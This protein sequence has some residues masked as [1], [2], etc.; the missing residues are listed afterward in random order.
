MTIA[1][2]VI[3]YNYATATQSGGSLTVG[4]G[5][6]PDRAELYNAAASVWN[7]AD[8]SGAT[9]GAD[10]ASFIANA[11][12][13]EKTGGTGT[14]TIAT[15]VTNTG[16]I[17]AAS[18]V[19]DFQGAVAGTGADSISDASTLEFDSSAAAGQTV[20]FAGSGGT[21]IIGSLQTF[22][23]TLS[24]Y[25]IGG[26]GGTNDAIRLLGSWSE[27]G[28]SE[29][30]GD[31]LGT[32]TLFNGTVHETLKFAGSYTSA[33]FHVSRWTAVRT[34]RRLKAVAS[35][36]EIRPRRTDVAVCE[37]SSPCRFA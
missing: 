28:F 31:T 21:L 29:N 16:R 23:A 33:S 27:T 20:G 36:E 1:G 7:I 32:L 34:V 13:F 3:V 8:N 17:L 11:G 35:G 25:D 14:S 37:R 18:G 4:D 5:V 9:R 24:G 6:S 19:V 26:A 30:G 2:D 10:P 15:S 12:L 22:A